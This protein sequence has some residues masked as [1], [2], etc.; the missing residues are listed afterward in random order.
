MNYIESNNL[1]REIL[2]RKPMHRKFLQETLKELTEV[3]R[4]EA[5][6]YISFLRKEGATINN[7]AESYVTLVADMFREEM[8]FK[9]TGRYRCSSYEEA[10]SAIYH[11]SE[12][13]RKYMIGL[14]LSSFWWVNHV[15][16]RRFFC[17]HVA[18][19]TGN[20]YREI[21]PGHGLYFLD[22]MRKANFNT[23]EG[24]D[25]SATSVSLTE[26]IINSGYFGNFPKAHIRQADFISADF[27][28]P[29]DALVMGE[30]LEHVEN[31][32]RLLRCAHAVTKDSA[33][34]FLTTCFNSPAVDH[35]Y[36]PGSLGVLEELI[37]KSGFK[38]ID[39][40]VL[41]KQGCTMEQC[42]ENRLSVNVALVI[43]KSSDSKPRG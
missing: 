19:K 14:A 35:I 41:P 42:T 7:L 43:A 12:Y 22:A 9:D 21:G 3:E 16:M 5:E 10:A 37:C 6:H 26:R 24:V 17:K 4:A 28:Q 1:V 27:P 2:R 20:I 29:A 38:I 23:Y 18:G 33:F 30:V 32:E 11:N 34:V 15:K 25:I 13:M 39:N 36:N 8:H 31:P 40:C